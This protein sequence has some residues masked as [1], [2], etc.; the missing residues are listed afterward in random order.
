MPADDYRYF[1]LYERLISFCGDL[2]DWRP[3]RV[4]G[5][6][7][8]SISIVPFEPRRHFVEGQSL[9]QSNKKTQDYIQ[10]DPEN[11]KASG[12]SIQIPEKILDRVRESTRYSPHEAIPYI[13][14]SDTSSRTLRAFFLHNGMKEKIVHVAFSHRNHAGAL[15]T[16]TSLLAESKFNILTSILRRE[17]DVRNTWEVL[18]EYRGDGEV[19]KMKDSAEEARWT[20]SKLNLESKNNRGIL[21]QFGVFIAT[22]RYPLTKYDDSCRVPLFADEDEPSY[23]VNYSVD[24][25]FKRTEEAIR[26]HSEKKKRDWLVSLFSPGKTTKPRIFYSYPATAA[27]HAAL[28]Q[29]ALKPY[30][31]CDQYQEPNAEDIAS[32]VIGRIQQCDYFLAVWHPEAGKPTEISPWMPFEFGIASVLGKQ[33]MIVVASTID[34]RN[35]RRID[36]HISRHRYTDNQFAETTVQ[37]IVAYALKHWL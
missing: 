24:E 15:A 1:L 28:I 6:E 34:E 2:L 21:R 16:I 18:L 31:D 30:F 5:R 20:K 3:S 17:D 32:S 7:I 26:S 25:A 8:P 19:P 4:P 33:S 11:K 29:Q 27:L 12:C 35:W 10:A 23:D 13:I 9:V 14:V 36:P 22:P 37:A